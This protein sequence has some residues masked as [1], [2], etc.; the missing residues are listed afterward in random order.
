MA[1]R[2]R[3]RFRSVQVIRVAEVAV[4]DVRRPYIKQLLE[5]GLKFP[6]PHRVPRASSRRYRTLFAAKRPS[7]YA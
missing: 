3:A 1:S 2:H 4:A 5:P 6:L 7:T